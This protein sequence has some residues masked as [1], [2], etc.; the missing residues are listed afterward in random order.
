MLCCHLLKLLLIGCW[1]IHEF[2]NDLN[3]IPS[4]AD[5]FLQRDI[6]KGLWKFKVVVSDWGSIREMIDHGFAPDRTEAGIS[7]S[8]WI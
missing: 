7:C 2:I 3:G 4:T 5:K 8:W 6:L 1:Y